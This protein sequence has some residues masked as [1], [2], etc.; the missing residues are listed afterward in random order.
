MKKALSI[1]LFLVCIFAILSGCSNA[2]APSTETDDDSVT[3]SPPVEEEILP[4]AIE[5]ER[6]TYSTIFDISSSFSAYVTVVPENASI[7][8]IT[9]TSSNPD[10]ATISSSGG[11]SAT[12]I[13]KAAGIT[14]ITAT[15]SN[16]ITDTYELEVKPFLV[17]D[18]ELPM[19]FT[20]GTSSSYRRIY[21]ITDIQYSYSSYYNRLTFEVD[22]TKTFDARG[23]SNATSDLI[24][25]LS[26]YDEDGYQIDTNTIYVSGLLVNDKTVD[27][28][29]IY[30]ISLSGG[31]YYI[32]LIA[33]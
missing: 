27:E 6:Y 19:T 21:E 14:T 5:I 23:N 17:Y 3:A 4:T 2:S 22:C 12:I 9:W 20:E 10:V 8:E 26:I 1:I 29:T 33:D 16:G 28:V 13:P 32:R 25:R 31:P 7:K 15:T 30:D 24:A 18:F 11:T